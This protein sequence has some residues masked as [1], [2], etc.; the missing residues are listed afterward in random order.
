M[1]LPVGRRKN[2]LREPAKIPSPGPKYAAVS[3]FRLIA[4][5]LL[6][7]GGMGEVYRARDTRLGREVTLKIPHLAGLLHVS[8]LVCA[9]LRKHHPQAHP[10]EAGNGSLHLDARQ[11]QAFGSLHEP[12]ELALQV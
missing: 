7:K 8:P 5:S 9:D 10:D 12:D 2:G 4:A 1:A 3:T 6:G 11:V